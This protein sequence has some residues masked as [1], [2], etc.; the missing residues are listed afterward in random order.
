MSRS[1]RIEHNKYKFWLRIV[2]CLLIS[3][4]IL[5]GTYTTY[6]FVNTHDFKSP[7]VLKIQNPFPR[8]LI[9]IESPVGTRSAGFVT[10]AYAEEIKNPYEPKSP[11]AVAWEVIKDTFGVDQ[12]GSFET[13]VQ[14][15]SGWNPFS[16]NR[17]S[18]ACGLPQSLPCSK[19]NCELWDYECQVKWMASY[20]KDRYETPDKAL[21]FHNEKGWY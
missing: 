4:S 14:Q 9:T 1:E 7:I 18:N 19:M 8:K 16:I 13:I 17:S 5:W 3:V 2:I 15:E 20:I 11:K 12:W 6:E 10:K 21:A